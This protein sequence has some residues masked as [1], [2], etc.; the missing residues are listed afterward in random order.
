MGWILC[1]IRNNCIRI[2]R[3]RKD[4]QHSGQD[5]VFIIQLHKIGWRGEEEDA[6]KLTAFSPNEER[7]DWIQKKKGHPM[8]LFFWMLLFFPDASSLPTHSYIWFISSHFLYSFSS[9]FFQLL[10]NWITNNNH[11]VERRSSFPTLRK[12][13][14][15]FQ[16]FLHP[17]SF[18]SLWNQEF[19][20]VLPA[21]EGHQFR[22][23]N[24][25][26]K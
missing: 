26:F 16:T 4:K 8:A 20:S 21:I 13:R 2:G 22:D 10:H 7:T 1:C 12:I 24:V 19:L 11:L 15:S 23:I 9:H 5:V 6:L 25:F 17:P 18:H 14:F 3:R